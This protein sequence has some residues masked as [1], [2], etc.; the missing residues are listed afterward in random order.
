MTM[1]GYKPEVVG[2][3]HL[4]GIGH[5]LYAPNHTSFLD[6]LTLTGFVPRPMK[7]VSKADILKIPFIGW[8]MRLAGHIALHTDSRRSQLETF[9]KSVGELNHN[10]IP[11]S[12]ERHSIQVF[13]PSLLTRCAALQMATL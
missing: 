2:L 6:I 11:T 10:P 5:C 12:I 1:C 8:P 3:E 4:N 7:Y 13:C 9:R